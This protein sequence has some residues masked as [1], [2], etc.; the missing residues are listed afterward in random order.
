MRFLFCLMLCLPMLGCG[1]DSDK[2]TT[3][4]SETEED[5]QS[6]TGVQQTGDTSTSDTHTGDDLT[7]TTSPGDE[8]AEMACKH[9]GKAKTTLTLA[10]SKNE[11]GTVVLLPKDGTTAVLLELPEKGDGWLAFEATDW[12]SS[13]RF[14]VDEGVDY[15]IMGG[16]LITEREANAACPK[17]G[18]TDQRW[19]FHEWG[20]YLIRFDEDSPK[21]VWFFVVKE[22]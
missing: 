8:F 4:T 11:A 9:N 2:V 13:F 21:T 19:Y 22:E 12:M 17:S 18:M 1:G 10:G 3:S 16:E 7:E 20:S 15:E 6:H 5:T 14:F